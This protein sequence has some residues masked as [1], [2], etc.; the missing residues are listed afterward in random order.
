VH[1]PDRDRDHLGARCL[2][3]T[4]HDGVRRV[5]AGADDQPRG[6]RFIRNFQEIVH[7]YL[8]RGRESNRGERRDRQAFSS[9][10]VPEFLILNSYFLIASAQP[11]PK[12]FTISI[13]SP[14]FTVVRSK[15]SRLSTVRLCSTATR[16]ASICSC[17]RRSVTV[18]GPAKSC[19]SPFRVIRKADAHSSAASRLTA[20]TA[21]AA[22]GQPAVSRALFCEL[23]GLRG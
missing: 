3:G 2:V 15:A 17:A 5:L 14:S 22:G 18:R 20:E 10:A 16:R 9:I 23:R 8:L 6:K 21:D 13:S 11:P 1:P 12:K 19:G 4:H 7:G